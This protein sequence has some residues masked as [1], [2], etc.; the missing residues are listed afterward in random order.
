MTA[1]AFG[2]YTPIPGA[3]TEQVVAYGLCAAVLVLCLWQRIRPTGAGVLVAGLW[4]THFLIAA[5][6]S[7]QTAARPAKFGLGDPVAG[8]D[9]H[10]LPV[11]VIATA[12]M[13]LGHN[14]SRR[15]L[16]AACITLVAAMCINTA[17]AIWSINTDLT[18]LLRSFWAGGEGLTTAEKAQLGGRFGGVFN[19]PA[20][21][22]E[23]C[24]MALLAA[25]WLYRTRPWWLAVAAGLI[26]VG[27]VVAASKN[28]LLVG[29]PVGAWQLLRVSSGRQRQLVGLACLL[30]V[31]VGATRFGVGTDW[32]GGRMV[33]DLLQPDGS[34]YGATDLY[35][36]GR[37]GDR[38]TIGPVVDAVLA[39]SPWFGFG[40][41]GVLAAYDNA[42]LEALAVA[43]LTG[44]A[45]YTA[46][47]AILAAAW[48][49]R[50][51]LV[52]KAW[53]QFS[54]GLIIVLVG[55]SMG[56]PALTANRVATVSWLLV[57]LLLLC[58]PPSNP[59]VPTPTKVVRQPIRTRKT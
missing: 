21:A 11:A 47:L 59:N 10:L 45:I 5:A 32:A 20:E 41:G 3:R 35:T 57:T 44:A 43:G 4:G 38:S 27:G 37:F 14:D 55:A 8:F 49:H 34:G 23:M 1:A 2:P 39:A 52:D 12:W 29:L 16:H 42:W 30:L 24:S 26:A 54:G 36:A 18:W 7:M 53:S 33:A 48:W 13:L 25:I 50:R 31:L 56:L 46:V 19:Q 9:N 6:G 17:L 15:L 51:P 40:A 22:G 58:P 28:F